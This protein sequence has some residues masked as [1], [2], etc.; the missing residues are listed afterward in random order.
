MPAETFI[1]SFSIKRTGMLVRIIV[2]V[3]LFKIYFQHL[4]PMA[5]SFLVIGTRFEFLIRLCLKFPRKVI[6]FFVE[7]NVLLT[8]TSV[9]DDR[10]IAT[11]IYARSP[12]INRLNR[13]DASRLF[14]F[15]ITVGSHKT[16]KCVV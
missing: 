7:S 9:V 16:S 3:F 6:A 10:K 8:I 14:A 5:V 1:D 13:N 2:G 11:V 4:I 12:R 15:I